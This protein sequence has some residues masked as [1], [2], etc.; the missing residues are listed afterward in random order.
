MYQNIVAPDS[1]IRH[2][3]IHWLY[4]KIGCIGVGNIEYSVYQIKLLER[5]LTMPDFDEQ[6]LRTSCTVQQIS[7]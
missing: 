2:T 4:R 5:E 1:P 6:T 3:L 7:R